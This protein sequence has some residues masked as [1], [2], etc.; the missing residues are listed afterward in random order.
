MQHNVMLKILG[1][2]G[3]EGLVQGRPDQ[4]VKD[5][6]LYDQLK[7]ASFPKSTEARNCKRKY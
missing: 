2:R 3:W 5:A 4:L 6:T 1:V 7:T